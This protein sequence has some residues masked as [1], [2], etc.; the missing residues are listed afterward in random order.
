MATQIARSIKILKKGD[1]SIDGYE[2][3]TFPKEY[4]KTKISNTNG[5][6]LEKLLAMF[7][8]YSL[9]PLDSADNY[10]WW[11]IL[12]T[13]NDLNLKDGKR[14]ERFTELANEDCSVK[15]Y[16]VELNLMTAKQGIVYGKIDHNKLVFTRDKN[17]ATPMTKYA[18]KYKAQGYPSAKIKKID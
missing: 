6:A 14:L 5:K 16:I 7:D 1:I 11:G 8:D 4:K 13:L 10:K 18:S 15:E 3:N 2:Q 9:Q 12:K 17:N